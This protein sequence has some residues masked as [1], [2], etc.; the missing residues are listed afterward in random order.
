MPKVRHWLVI[1]L[2]LFAGA[3]ALGLVAAHTPATRGTE[4]SWDADIQRLRTGWLNRVMLDLANVASPV[5]G[6]AVLA[7]ITLFLLWRRN[8]VRAVATF[9]VIAV[10]WNS[11]EI[12]K[13]LVARHR[14]PV[15]VSLA[16]ETGSNS[17]PSGH[18]A[19]AVS[20]AIAVAML[21][22]GTRWFRLVVV[23]GTLWT[24]LIAFSRLYIGAHYPLDVLGSVVVST[25]AIVFL[26]GL[27]HGWI[28][29]N[30][31]RVPLLAR[32]GPVPGPVPA[33]ETAS[34][35]S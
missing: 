22:A 4:L 16:P 24:A 30:L 23:L 29:D 21:A 15:A 19:F 28:A 31:H 14:P 9:L 34:V 3:V 5:A 1:S 11:S 10:G 33:P 13:L 8:P 2:A 25:A 17:F 12:A 35:V 18:V 7:L 27:W 32:F 26:T 20:L 6:L